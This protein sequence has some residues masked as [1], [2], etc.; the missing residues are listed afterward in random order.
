M[1]RVFSTGGIR[2]SQSDDGPGQRDKVGQSRFCPLSNN[3]QWHRVKRDRRDKSLKGCP[4]VPSLCSGLVSKQS[5]QTT[6]NTKP[7]IVAPVV[8]ISVVSASNMGPSC[9]GAAAG[10]SERSPSVAKS[11]SLF[12]ALIENNRKNRDLRK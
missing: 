6:R 9:R 12:A 10:V 2:F 11:K 8:Q 5:Y 1:R 3:R 7:I 4:V